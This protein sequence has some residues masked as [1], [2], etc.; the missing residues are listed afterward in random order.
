MLI[1]A[2][3][4]I[5]HIFLF[6]L[7]SE[8]LHCK[9]FIL[10]IGILYQISLIFFFVSEPCSYFIDIVSFNLLVLRVGLGFFVVLFCL[11]VFLFGFPCSVGYLT[12]GL[13]HASQVLYH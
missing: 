9:L 1:F 5:F 10:A 3:L 13:E 11:F 2:L 12:Q 8:S 6:R 7:L 4:L